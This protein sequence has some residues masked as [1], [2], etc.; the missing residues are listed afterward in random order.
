MATKTAETTEAST[1]MTQ[2]V[3]IDLGAQK[4]KSIKELKEGEGELWDEVFDVIDEVKDM[5]GKEAEG[6]VL[7]PVVMLYEKKQSQRLDL[8]KILFPL[9]NR[10]EDDE[11]DDEEE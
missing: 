7:I 5:L 8:D 3:I 4:S 1:E 11:D 2:P 6:K 9:L 10:D